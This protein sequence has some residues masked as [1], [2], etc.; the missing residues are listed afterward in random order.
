MAKL[1]EYK[2]RFEGVKLKTFVDKYPTLWDYSHISQVLKGKL[3]MTEIMEMRLQEAMLDYQD[4]KF[5]MLNK[6]CIKKSFNS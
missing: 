5:E 6:I 4:D 2:K 1:A 3:P